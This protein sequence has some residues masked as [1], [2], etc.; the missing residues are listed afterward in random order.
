MTLILPPSG[1]ALT[2]EEVDDL[3][4]KMERAIRRPVMWGHP[5]GKFRR[6]LPLPLKT[7]IRLRAQRR[8][9]RLCVWLCGVRRERA[10]M[11]IW[12]ATGMIK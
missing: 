7:R 1:G 5:D 9:D 10:A 6:C 2:D 11:A 12:K 8:V 4:I 3:R